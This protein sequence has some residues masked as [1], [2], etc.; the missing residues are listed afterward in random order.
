MN[1]I[2]IVLVAAVVLVAGYLLYGRWLAR[3]WGIDAK[4]IT[5]AR[6][7]E[8]G[9]NFS[10]ASCFTAFSHQFSS[11]CGAG[12]VTGTIAAMMFGWLPVL[13]WVLVGGIFFGAVHDFGALYASVKNN[14]KSLAQLI[15][16]YIGR[17]GRKL[18]LL[19]S[20][21]FTIIVIAAFAFIFWRDYRISARMGYINETVQILGNIY[22]ALYRIDYEE[23]TY[24]MIKGSSYVRER[25]PEKGDYEALLKV[26][27]EVIEEKAYR[28]GAASHA[29]LDIEQ[30]YYSRSIKY[31]V[32]GNILRNGTYPI[33]VSSERIFQA[34]AII[35]Y[36]KKIGADYVAHGSTGAGNDQVRFDLT[37]QILAPQIGIITPTR[38]LTLTR[39][40]I[41]SVELVDTLPATGT[42]T[43]G[44]GGVSKSYGHFYFDGYGAC[45]LYVYNDTGKYVC[46]RL[47]GD[48]P[49]YVF[50]NAETV[51]A[52]ETLYAEISQWYGGT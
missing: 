1:G 20:W 50:L 10:P 28:L 22:Y 2:V 9:K 38:D 36:A 23:K 30:E 45:D 15:E 3:T 51:D 29:T 33:S 21:L 43:N 48:D 12:P 8:D 42:R 27:G 52:T 4:A 41:E 7:M 35:E 5:P 14:G 37:F 13:L 26:A 31:M 46:L 47:S 40:Q 44:Y 18:F 19:F 24:T 34:I 39:E 25:L 17:T 16:K 32:F 6:R 11:I 49:A